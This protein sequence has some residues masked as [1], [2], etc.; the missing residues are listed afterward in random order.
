[1]LRAK[2]TALPPW[3]RRGMKY[4]RGG[5]AALVIRQT[6]AAYPESPLPCTQTDLCNEYCVW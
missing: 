3:L 2:H 5:V 6:S 1:M 4:R